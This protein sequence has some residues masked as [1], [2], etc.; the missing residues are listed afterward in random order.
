MI[1]PVGALGVAADLGRRGASPAP[2]WPHCSPR[3]PRPARPAH[4]SSTSTTPQSPAARRHAGAGP[5]AACE[6]S[7]R[8]GPGARPPRWRAASSTAS[9]S[10]YRRQACEVAAL[11][12]GIATRRWCTSSAAARSNGLLCRADRR[13]PAACPC[14]PGPLEAAALGN[15]LVQAQSPRRRPAR[16]RRRCGR[17]SARTHD[18][19]PLRA[20]GRRGLASDASADAAADR[21]APTRP[22][23]PGGYPRLLCEGESHAGRGADGDV[24]QR[25][26]VPRPR[27]RRW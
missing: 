11:V 21:L 10:A 25:R 19:G 16:P 17:W 20:G 12:A 5:H 8:A 3:R 6:E 23:A 27:G 22:A 18:L 7:G 9:R 2:T 1:R 13:R 15:V 14:S 24:H 26:D 4:S